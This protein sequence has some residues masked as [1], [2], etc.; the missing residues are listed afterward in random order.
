MVNLLLL[1]ANR[2]FEGPCYPVCK[3]GHLPELYK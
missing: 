1:S 3:G 2:D